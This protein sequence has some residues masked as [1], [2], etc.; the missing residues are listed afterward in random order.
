MDQRFEIITVEKGE[1]NLD[2]YQG[3]IC[4]NIMRKLIKEMVD[5]R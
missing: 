1:K 4:I 5:Y 2:Y 3:C